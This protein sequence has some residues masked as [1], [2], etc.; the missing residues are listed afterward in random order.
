MRSY[1]FADLVTFSRASANEAKT[2]V[3]KGLIRP[4]IQDT[5]GTGDRRRFGF[6]DVF[7]ARVAC[8]L[9]RIPGGIPTAALAMALAVVRAETTDLGSPWGEFVLKFETRERSM[10]MDDD[11]GYWLWW[12]PGTGPLVVS[13]KGRDEMF[14]VDE[15]LLMVRLDTLLFELEERTQDRASAPPESMNPVPPSLLTLI[16]A[17]LARELDTAGLSSAQ[18]QTVF[19]QL[20][21]QLAALRPER[22]AAAAFVRY[23]EMIDAIV[24]INGP[25]PNYQKWRKGVAAFMAGWKKKQVPLDEQILQILAAR[26]AERAEAERTGR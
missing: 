15:V 23:V 5:T 2:W 8:E 24:T 10:V 9:N 1:G 14:R 20:R 6:L 18:V 16:E 19:D 3:Q 13:R 12:S 21:G 22:R 11:F 4:T 25:G 26:D 7:E 17:S